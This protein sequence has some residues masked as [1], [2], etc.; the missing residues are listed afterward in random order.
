M[1]APEPPCAKKGAVTVAAL[2]ASEAPAAVLAAIDPTRL[3]DAKPDPSPSAAPKA[4]A[5]VIASGK[6]YTTQDL[7][8]AQLEVVMNGK[9]P[10]QPVLASS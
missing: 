8:K 2:P 5:G 10:D 1:R 7:A 4:V 3:V 6:T 9:T